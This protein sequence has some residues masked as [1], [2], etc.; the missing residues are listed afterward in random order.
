V[1]GG[2]AAQQRAARDRL[3]LA[4]PARL[5]QLAGDGGLPCV[6]KLEWLP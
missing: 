4:R 6:K 5:V 1:R 2:D 3:E